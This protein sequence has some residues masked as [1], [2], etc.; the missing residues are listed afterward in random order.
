[1]P[2][3][4]WITTTALTVAGLVSLGISA[5]YHWSGVYLLV[6]PLLITVGVTASAVLA[7]LRN[8]WWVLTLMTGI[9][10]A[11]VIVRYLNPYGIGM[12]L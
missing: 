8:P 11:F 5:A 7:G 4:A 2:L 1:L 9:L 12:Y 6:P 10:V 3:A